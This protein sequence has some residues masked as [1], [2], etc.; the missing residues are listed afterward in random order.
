MKYLYTFIFALL[1]AF[2]LQA[3]ESEWPDM[4]A[5]TMDIVYYPQEVAWRNYLTGEDRN[6][7]PKIKLL[8]SRPQKNDRVIFGELVPYGKE[9]RLGANEATTITFYEAVDIGGKAVR[10]GVYTVFAEV[11]PDN[12]TFRF[13]SQTGIW[14]AAN[15]DRDMDVASVTVPSMKVSEMSEALSMTFQKVDDLHCNL[16]VEWDHTRA[17]VPIAFNPVIF[18]GLDPS[19]MDMAHYPAKSA[20]TNYLEGDERN[21]K[22]KIQ[23]VYSRPYKK[24]R[25]VFG[26][27]IKKGDMW[28]IGANESTEIVL[29]E[30]MVVGDL[31]LRAGRYALLAEIKDGSW[32]IIF[33]K[34][35]PSWGMAN[36]D[37]SKDVGR[38]NVP[39]RMADDVIENLSITFEEKSPNLVH[40]KIAW[41]KTRVEVPFKMGQ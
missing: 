32:D 20:Y 2:T 1:F 15:R 39:V 31:P 14:G 26:D 30:N 27:L 12:W 6:I 24:G 38:V 3:Q 21:I 11:D 7:A 29:Y 25:N 13:S 34:D 35:Y 9:W 17:S 5:S 28:R 4:D 41:D 19:P 10:P 18:N 22:P 23:V 37:E 36:R 8:Y 33:S 16:V 40:M